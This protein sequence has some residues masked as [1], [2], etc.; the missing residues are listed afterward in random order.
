VPPLRGSAQ[1]PDRF[2]AL[3]AGLRLFRPW[4]DSSATGLLDRV[5]P[6]SDVS[7]EMRGD[8][9]SKVPGA[10]RHSGE[11]R[12]QGKGFGRAVSESEEAARLAGFGNRIGICCLFGLRRSTIR[13]FS[14]SGIE[15]LLHW[16]WQALALV[17]PTLL[18]ISLGLGCRVGHR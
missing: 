12:S 1:S 17:M 16:S 10:R 7:L 11:W 4:R 18:P 3:R 6:L 8:D 13:P 2:P 5:I 14:V 9:D 15:V